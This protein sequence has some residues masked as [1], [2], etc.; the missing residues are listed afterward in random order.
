MSKQIR[1]E[2]RTLYLSKQVLTTMVVATLLLNWIK[3]LFAR[4]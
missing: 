1:Y 4:I 2:Y 3:G